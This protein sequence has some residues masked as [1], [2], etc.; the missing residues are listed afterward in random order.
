MMTRS[1]L[2][3][4]GSIANFVLAGAT[5]A[6]R[7]TRT[8]GASRVRGALRR[9]APLGPL[10][11]ALGAY[12]V[13]ASI[14]VACG[15]EPAAV[16][17]PQP[18]ETPSAAPAPEASAPAEAPTA[19][20]SAKAS[21]APAPKS[22]DSGRPAVLKRDDTEITDTFGSSPA[23]KLELGEKDFATLRLPEGALRTGTLITFKIAKNARGIAGLVG[24]VYEIK[25]VIP[26]SNDGQAMESNGPPFVL[27][28]PAGAK[29]DANL[30]IGVEDKGKYKW[31]I[32]APKR[33][34]DARN[35]AVFELTTLPSGLLHVTTKAPTE[36]K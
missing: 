33:V 35:V 21:A 12:A 3:A 13:A 10:S 36:G 2:G 34:D 7:A 27:E 20:A 28:M 9:L 18:S 32:V 23:S 24:K 29:K 26:P 4:A 15:G 8:T 31:T 11:L 1:T 22:S 19:S 25:N 5:A 14:V 17:P 16:T 6:T 30:A